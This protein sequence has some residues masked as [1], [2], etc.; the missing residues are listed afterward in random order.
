MPAPGRPFLR[1]DGRTGLTAGPRGW[2][3]VATHQ[4]T[5]PPEGALELAARADGPLG[6][7]SPNDDLGGLAL[8]PWLAIAA[9]GRVLLLDRRGWLLRL[10]PSA[11]RFRSLPGLREPAWSAVAATAQSLA[12]TAPDLGRLEVRD[13]RNL[14]LRAVLDSRTLGARFR[15]IAIAGSGN[16]LW[17]LDAGEQR[18]LMLRDGRERPCEAFRLPEDAPAVHRILPTVD[19]R[20]ALKIVA[21]PRLMLFA[22]DGAALGAVDQAAELRRVVAQPPFQLDGRGRFRPHGAGGPAFDW[23]GRT[24][25]VRP[26]EP[27]GA[28]AFEC[29]GTWI[30]TALAGGTDDTG[31]HRFSIRLERFPPGSRLLVRTLTANGTAIGGRDPSTIEADGWDLALRA[32][33]PLQPADPQEGLQQDGWVPSPPGR[34]LWLRLELAGTGHATPAVTRIDVR[35][36]GPMP[37]DLL[38]PVFREDQEGARFLNRFLDLPAA[39]FERIEAGLAERG[40][41]VDPRLATPEDLSRLARNLG[42]VLEETWDEA[43]RRRLLTGARREL[44]RRGTP[45]ALRAQLAAV[46]AAVSGHDSPRLAGFPRLLEGFRERRVLRLGRG[47][48]RVG[49]A[50][51]I[52]C[53]R[54]GPGA[55][56]GTP[57]REGE[58]RLAGPGDEATSDLRA[59]A[60]RVH[61]FVPAAF[62]RDQDALDAFE[63]AIRREKPTH[64]VHE[65]HR[66]RAGVIVGR[67][68]TLGLDTILGDRRPVRLGDGAPGPRSGA[69]LGVDAGL[70][71]GRHGRGIRMTQGLR[72]AGRGPRI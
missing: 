49:E 26:D 72:L 13:A 7:A 27:A 3:T 38:P 40:R 32:A 60:H 34:Y 11:D 16:V 55:R 37:A 53:Q 57:V 43:D 9:D 48:P 52:W 6:L 4:L 47:T 36:D 8:P 14:S 1:L 54:D 51:P 29:D 69:R 59:F 22:V 66:V 61:I 63:R 28:Q 45:A 10:E 50:V 64:V 35:Y 20:I 25:E 5:A 18:I 42:V 68:S 24:V 58:A 31:W 65:L 15:P 41:I 46:L 30:S 17:I 33:A 2:P 44:T 70:A 67:Q 12:L 56:L 62:L 19:G 39:E 23:D 71:A 21:R